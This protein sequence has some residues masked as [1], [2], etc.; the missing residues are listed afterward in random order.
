MNGVPIP[1]PFDAPL[2]KVVTQAKED[3]AKRLAININ[4]VNLVELQSVTWPDGSLGCPQ[5]GMAY[6]Q[7][8]VDG[9]LIR[10]SAGANSYEYHSGGGR[11]PFLCESK[12]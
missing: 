1:P 5:P 2:E 3:L 8:T 4:Q 10:L 9:L 11:A 6:T 12:S 7:V